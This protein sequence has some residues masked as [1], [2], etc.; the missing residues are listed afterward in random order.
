MSAPRGRRGGFRALASGSTPTRSSGSPADAA[1]G[2][3]TSTTTPSASASASASTSASAPKSG[4]ASTTAVRTGIN[5]PPSR[6]SVTTAAGTT[7]TTISR[8]AVGRLQSLKKRGPTGI[9]VPLN[10]DGATP[11]P[12][13]RYQP[14]AVARRSKEERFKIEQQE[15]EENKKRAAEAAAIRR[16][17][18]ASSG[19]GRGRGRGRGRGS[20]GAGDSRGGRAGFNNRSIKMEYGGSGRRSGT[21]SGVNSPASS[22]ED[23]TGGRFSIEQINIDSDEENEDV[24]DDD[25]EDRIK[26]KQPER[27][28]AA[29]KGMR[30]ERL[31]RHEH[32]ERQV[33]VNTEAAASKSAQK[34]IEAEKQAAEWSAEDED[35]SLFFRSEDDEDYESD[36][37]EITDVRTVKGTDE[38]AESGPRIKQE[39]D[40]DVT[41]VDNIFSRTAKTDQ[42]ST[43]PRRKGKKTKKVRDPRSQLQTEEERQEYDRYAQEVSELKRSLGTLTTDDTT[44]E[45][46]K[47]EGA[48][49]TEEDKKRAL[50]RQEAEIIKAE[51]QQRLF[52]VQFP[53]MTPNLID[54]VNRAAANQ[55]SANA[56]TDT[57]AVREISNPDGVKQESK[58]TSPFAT[59]SISQPTSSPMISATHNK[60]PPGQAGKLQIHASGRA[61]ITWGGV[62][63]ELNKGSDVSFLQD[64]ILMEE[65]KPLSGSSTPSIV[66][67]GNTGRDGPPEKSIWAMSQVSGKFVVSPDWDAML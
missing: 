25:G 52:L 3:Q 6:G 63:F 36:Q 17:H 21:Q 62:R 13:L 1:S 34:K 4:M 51:R 37:A 61:T 39:P 53:P 64:A 29:S 55:G 24:D 58:E 33:G 59:P 28:S 2:D 30:P 8:T 12:T 40:T 46:E 65:Q 45:E 9:P 22:D 38:A 43:L 44:T 10:P 35:E 11:K 7:T 31:E 41:M 60:V 5:A 20:R 26:G 49:L 15:V 14:R 19:E 27:A 50:Q 54:P 42:Q 67:A 18:N 47:P 56:T 48:E 16:A 66:A 23:E 57:D 32:I